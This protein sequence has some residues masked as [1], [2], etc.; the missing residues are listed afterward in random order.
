[1]CIWLIEFI[2]APPRPCSRTDFGIQA[3]H[4]KLPYYLVKLEIAL[5]EPNKVWLNRQVRVNPFI[6]S[7]K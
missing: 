4:V 3:G 1:M 6:P 5:E 7:K 2:P